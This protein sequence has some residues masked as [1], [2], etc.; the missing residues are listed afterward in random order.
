M[1]KTSV[2]IAVIFSCD[3]NFEIVFFRKI[4]QYSIYLL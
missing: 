4:K 2:T 3:E 1:K